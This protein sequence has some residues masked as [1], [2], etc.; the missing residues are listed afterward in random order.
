MKKLKLVTFLAASCAAISNL[1]YA[2]EEEE[3][4]V[5]TN[6][7]SELIPLHEANFGN[8]A[9]IVFRTIRAQGIN[10][11]DYKISL[12][13]CDPSNLKDLRKTDLFGKQTNFEYQ[14]LHTTILWDVLKSA[15]SQMLRELI[16]VHL[17][18]QQRVAHVSCVLPELPKDL[19]HKVTQIK[20]YPVV[21]M[22]T[23]LNFDLGGR[24]FDSIKEIKLLAEEGARPIYGTEQLSNAELRNLKVLKIHGYQTHVNGLV[25][26]KYPQLEILDIGFDG[27]ASN[28]NKLSRFEIHGKLFL[29][30]QAIQMD[31]APMSKNKFAP[32]LFRSGLNCFSTVQGE[33]VVNRM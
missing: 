14:R 12:N 1:S 10:P 32:L 9:K 19:E 5:S 4:V 25:K 29:N 11:L 28:I 16:A 20:V 22:V 30:I 18:E 6:N 21:Q 13:I 15:F 31:L 24:V 33:G 26:C 8:Q 7:R 27:V 3:P 17:P 23:N 2:M